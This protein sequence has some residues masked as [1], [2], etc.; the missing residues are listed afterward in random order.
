M[1]TRS[2]AVLQLLEFP[3]S[4]SSS[5]SFLPSSLSPLFLPHNSNQPVNVQPQPAVK[6]EPGSPPDEKP[7][8]AKPALLATPNSKD[9]KTD[10]PS[11]PPTAS[12]HSGSKSKSRSRTRS[13]SSSPPEKRR[14]RS[15]RQQRRSRSRSPRRRRQVSTHTTIIHHLTITYMCCILYAVITLF[16]GDL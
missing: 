11:P 6:P 2:I 10:N 9:T 1:C 3:L 8:V 15:P 12:H 4:S 13:P 14:S 7:K 5:S 16:S